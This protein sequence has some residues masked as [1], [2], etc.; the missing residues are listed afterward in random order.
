MNYTPC[1][2]V[3]HMQPKETLDHPAG[4]RKTNATNPVIGE[5]PF[6]RYRIHS[7]FSQPL[8]II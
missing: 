8:T 5:S 6:R 1:S 4:N 3:A 7:I 2:K